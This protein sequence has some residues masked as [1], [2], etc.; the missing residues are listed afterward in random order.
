LDNITHSLVGVA[1]ADL[2]TRQRGPRLPRP[3]VAGAGIIAANLPDDDLVYTGITEPPIGYLLHHRGHTHTVIGLVAL[4]ILMVWVYRNL[5]PVRR[6]PSVERW[7]LWTL[8]VVALATHLL[9]DA[10]NS[11]GVHLYHPLDS[12]WYYGDS[13]FIFEPWI[14]LPLG[15]AAAWNARSRTGWL[16]ATLPILI[17]ILV[18]VYMG[19]VPAEGVAALSVAAVVFT[20][21]ARRRSPRTRAALALGVVLLVITGMMATSRHAHASA[22]EVL[23][24]HSSGGRLL[25]VI[26]TP[27][28]ASPLC[29]GVI[30]V[31]VD[32]ASDRYRFRRGTLSLAPA[33]KPPTA[34]ASHRLFADNAR[35]G[36]IAHGRFALSEDLEQP[37]GR[38]RDLARTNCRVR[39][40]LR[41]GRAPVIT[42][43]DIFDL[44][45]SERRGQNFSFMPLTSAR[46]EA[47]CP[48]FVPEWRMP[49][50]DL[51]E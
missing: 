7:R 3:L 2:S 36:I 15:V 28:P 51:L 10:L 50:A 24:G 9:L 25:D 19:I 43:T 37:L 39:A 21:T 23:R 18:I 29:W 16:A 17:L 42:G 11:Y 13:L 20:W 32:E 4:A 22:T 47:S 35:S 46:K 44:R 33:W 6:L 45:F 8:I 48:G 41:F 40:W 12:S 38:L 31:N 26:L 5:P 1:L 49:R 30:G 27:N 34:C 14:W